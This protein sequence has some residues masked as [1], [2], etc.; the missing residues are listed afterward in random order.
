MGAD[1]TVF[2]IVEQTFDDPDLYTVFLLE[3]KHELT[4]DVTKRIILLDDKFH[5]KKIYVDMT[6]L[7]AGVLD[8]LLEYFPEYKVEGISFTNKIKQDMYSNL[9]RLLE[10]RK[11]GDSGGLHLPKKDVNELT[12]KLYF[13]LR[14]LKQILKKSSKGVISVSDLKEG[15]ITEISHPPGGHDDY[16]TAL[17]LACLYWKE[18]RRKT[19]YGIY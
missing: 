6:G 7:G 18:I 14:D 1:S 11:R 19:G 16:C 17:G 15:I 3:V 8:N 10:K 5:F 9:K 4:T 2:V 12:K 13:Q